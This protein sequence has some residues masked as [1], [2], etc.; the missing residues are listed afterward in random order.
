MFFLANENP[1][2]AVNG[3]TVAQKEQRKRKTDSGKHAKRLSRDTGQW[4]GDGCR[5][6][7][8]GAHLHGI[9]MQVKPTNSRQIYQHQSS[10]DRS[11][12]EQKPL[13]DPQ[14]ALEG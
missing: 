7:W 4:D 14:L 10:P 6:I 3:H 11:Q 1:R 8:E 12:V 2:G 13:S 5:D 9:L